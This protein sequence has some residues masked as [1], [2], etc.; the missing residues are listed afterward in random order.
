MSCGGFLPAKRA[1]QELVELFARRHALGFI[2]L[3]PP[4]LLLDHRPEAIVG[5]LEVSRLRK[6]VDQDLARVKKRFR[7]EAKRPSSFIL[8]T[9]AVRENVHNILIGVELQNIQERMAVEN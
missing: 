9:A 2:S 6:I 5:P 8:R 1:V 7:N 3:S 4:G